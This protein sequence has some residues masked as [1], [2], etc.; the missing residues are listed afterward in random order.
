MNEPTTISILGCGWL[1]LPLAAQLVQAGYRVNGSTT[2]AEKLPL[3][4]KKGIQPF[5]INL[6]EERLAQ[7]A[8]QKFLQAQVLVLNIPPHLRSDGGEAYIN[9]MH[10]LLKAL[11]RSPVSRLLFV[12]STS[13]YPDLNRV[14]TE[15]DVVF[16]DELEP[17]N[18]LLQAE[19]LF[20]D[21]E[22][23]ITTIVRFS[24]LV[25]GTRQPGRFLAGKKD[26]LNGDAPVN[27]IHLDDCVAILQRILEQQQWGKVYNACALEHPMRKDF[28]TKAAVAIGLAPPEF[29]AMD[30]TAFKL[31]K[32]QK[33]QE[34]LAYTFIHPDP[35][36]FFS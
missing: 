33:L 10:L 28:Y 31:I 26:V 9:Q 30:K 35:M 16:T 22:E 1:G 21:R 20:Q 5:L 34:D 29:A 2:S 18:M 36:N 17:G 19:R 11:L 25:G 6:Q 24:G 3:L 27:L 32:S 8:L 15:E 14:V 13:V 7:E 23:W 12:S 4:A